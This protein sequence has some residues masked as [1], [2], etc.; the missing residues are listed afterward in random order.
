MFLKITHT[1]T[2]HNCH[3]LL[4]QLAKL[5][6]LFSP[7]VL[8][9]V[10]FISSCNPAPEKV[11]ENDKLVAKVFNKSL[12]QSD[13]DELV[14]G[15]TSPEDSAQIVNAYIERW[16]RASV[17]MHAAEKYV[18]DDLNIDE[19][20]RSYRASLIR[21]NYEELLVEM[22]L[23]S[24][25]NEGQ[26]NEYYQENKE[27]FKL[28]D[29]ILKCHF[30]KIPKS[31]EGWKEARAWWNS[32]KEEDY[33]KLVDFCSRNAEVYILNDSIWYP[34]DDISKYLPKGEL[35]NSNYLSVKNL[36]TS[37]D[38]YDYLLKISDSTP[39]GEYAPLAHIENQAVKVILHKRK[40]KLLEEKM[41]EM[42]E[43]ETRN[44]NVKIYTN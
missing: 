20:V 5:S 31:T 15:V 10:F 25:I 2:V 36:E 16:A 24:T 23:D 30:I 41:E 11:D 32:D 34:I 40:I 6:L 9:A 38:T 21:H 44:K 14:S 1:T 18:P 27:Q 33:K 35:T 7:V 17:L 26:L 29:P 37:D 3:S 42:Y 39:V 19:L 13:L 22:N 12:F 8:V 4:V 28:M 43:R